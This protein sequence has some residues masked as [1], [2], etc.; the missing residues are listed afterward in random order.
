MRRNWSIADSVVSC[1]D[2]L[3][4]SSGTSSV[5]PLGTI[6]LAEDGGEGAVAAIE[7]SGAAVVVGAVVVE[8][9]VILKRGLSA[10]PYCSMSAAI[11]SLLDGLV[12]SR[13]ISSTES[14]GTVGL[15]TTGM[16]V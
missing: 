13:G 3:V 2:G 9:D 12:R 6:V 7:E 1:L 4:R 8:S 10:R 15:S 16:G 5:V 11:S 14:V